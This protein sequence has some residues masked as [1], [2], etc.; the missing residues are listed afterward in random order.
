M[1][2][3][4]RGDIHERCA[5]LFRQWPSQLDLHVD[6]VEQ[7]LFGDAFCTVLSVFRRAYKPTVMEVQAP[8]P[9][10]R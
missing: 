7:A 3:A 5:F 10:S 1:D 6:S 9:T 2:R 8:R 4:F